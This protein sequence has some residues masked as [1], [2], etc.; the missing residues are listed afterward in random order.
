[1]TQE[2]IN[3]N[4]AIEINSKLSHNNRFYGFGKFWVAKISVKDGKIH[5]EFLQRTIT[6][7]SS[8]KT[9]WYY[10]SVVITEDGLYEVCEENS[11][12]KSRYMFLIRN[13]EIIYDE[14]EINKVLK[15]ML[16]NNK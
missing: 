1:M 3:E 12:K 5:R 7:K 14:N 6:Y 16:E 11:I 9:T 4:K 13:G 15:E 10:F 2:N 8:S